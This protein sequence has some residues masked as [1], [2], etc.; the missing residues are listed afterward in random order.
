MEN[1]NMMSAM[2]DNINAMMKSGQIWAQGFAEI[3]KTLAHMAQANMEANLAV[4]K[5][6]THAKSSEEAM[7]I[8]TDHIKASSDKTA[9]DTKS[10]TDTT[11]KLAHESMIAAKSNGD[12][13]NNKHR[14][15]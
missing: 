14:A 15:A 6:M 11:S 8:Q 3:S 13:T 7:N 2:S 4:M 10:L 12:N 1:Q 5:A 9:S